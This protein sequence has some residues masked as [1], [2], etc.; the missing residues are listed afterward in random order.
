MNCDNFNKVYDYLSYLNLNDETINASMTLYYNKEYFD[1]FCVF[2]K[3]SEYEKHTLQQLLYVRKSYT[4]NSENIKTGYFTYDNN[5]IK[6]I[7]PED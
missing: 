2:F 7:L 4:L 6:F 3:L 5:E 1:A